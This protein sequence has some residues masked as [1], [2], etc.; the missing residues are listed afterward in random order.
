ML[1]AITRLNH[2]VNS[3]AMRVVWMVFNLP[4]NQTICPVF[5][6]QKQSRQDISN[7]ADFGLEV[8]H[9]GRSEE[10]RSIRKLRLEEGRRDCNWQDYHFN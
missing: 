8:V 4:I 7:W 5:Q 6:I 1:T 10:N 2:R 3:F 9:T